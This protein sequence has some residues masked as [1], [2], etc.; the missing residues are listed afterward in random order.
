[1]RIDS[2]IIDMAR[3]NVTSSMR[4]DIF[5]H[6]DFT[7]ACT[8]DDFTYACTLDMSR[9]THTQTQMHAQTHAHAHTHIYTYTLT[10][11]CT[12]NGYVASRLWCNMSRRAY[13]AICCVAPILQYLAICRVA[14]ILQFVASRVCSMLQHVAT[15]CNMLQCVAVYCST[16]Q[17]IAAYCNV[18]CCTNE[19]FMS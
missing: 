7:C 3:V 15:C 18:P 1:M 12:L 6:V 13:V 11:A 4:L 8:W 16:L 9:Y 2:I 17:H 19:R 5:I 10:H 14:R